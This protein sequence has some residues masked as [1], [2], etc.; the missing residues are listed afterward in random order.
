MGAASGASLGAGS[1]SGAGRGAVP[2][3]VTVHDMIA[4]QLLR[5]VSGRF[6]SRLK[7]RAV[8]RASRIIAVSETTAGELMRLWGVP[9]SRIEVIPNGV[10]AFAMAEVGATSSAAPRVKR[11]GDQVLWVGERVD[12][13]NFWGALEAFAKSRTG[14]EAEWLCFGGGELRPEE[15]AR[16][17]R[18]GL[19]GRVRQESG[20]DA[21]LARVYAESTV[22]FY[23]SLHEGFGLPILEAMSAGC[24]V[25]TSGHGAMLEVAGEAARFVDPHDAGALSDTLDSVIFDAGEQQRLRDAGRARA[26][27]FSWRAT[28]ERHAELYARVVEGG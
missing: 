15:R 12:Y 21:A 16:I 9:Q 22:L 18:L 13:K 5:T 28:A 2:T 17:A 4:E 26:C 19:E 14:A 8:E 25:I 11:R 7:R 10:R 6:G 20:S 1:G 24:P 3:V 23:P 27:R